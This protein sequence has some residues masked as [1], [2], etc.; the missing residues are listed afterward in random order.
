M[1]KIK[2]FIVEDSSVVRENLIAALEESAPIDVIGVAEDEPGAIAWLLA[3]E[4]HSEN[5]RRCQTQ[6]VGHRISSM[7]ETKT[8]G[9][10]SVSVLI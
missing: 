10:S 9:R 4:H 7:V 5:Q 8:S 3:E 6:S 2:T 1:D